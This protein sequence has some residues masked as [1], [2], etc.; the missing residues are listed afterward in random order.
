MTI[1]IASEAPRQSELLEVMRL[2]DEFTRSLYPP[3]SCHLLGV[4]ELEAPGVTVFA[5]RDDGTVVGMAA[6]VDRGDGSAELKRMFVP[7]AA[8]GRGVA[9]ALLRTVERHAAQAGLTVLQLE[10]GPLQLAALA[11]YESCGFEL[12]PN[13]GKYAGDPNSVCFEKRLA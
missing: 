4:E 6:L 7:E 9:R 1:T 8:R 5:A 3:E 2:G 13:F 11:L 12:I 10:T